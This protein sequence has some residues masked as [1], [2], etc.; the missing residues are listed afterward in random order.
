[1]AGKKLVLF[2]YKQQKVAGS[3]IYLLQ[4]AQELAKKN[5]YEEVYYVNLANKNLEEMYSCEKVHYCDA[6]TCDYSVFDGADFFIP[7]NYL[8]VFLDKAKGVTK[9]KVLLYNWHPFLFQFLNNQFLPDRDLSGLY[10]MIAENDGIAFMDESCRVSSMNQTNCGFSRNYIPVFQSLDKQP[11][12]AKEIVNPNEINIGWMGRI[13]SDKV[14]AL[15]NLLD[16]LRKVKTNKQIVLHIIGDG[17]CT[18]RI[19]IGRYAPKIRMVFTSYLF[20]EERDTYIK[21]NIDILVTMGMSALDVANLGIPTLIAPLSLT[22]MDQNQYVLLTDVENY[23]LGWDISIFKDL[24]YRHYLLIDIIRMVYDDGKKN[25]LGEACYRFCHENFSLENSTCC[26]TTAMENTTLSIEKCLGNEVVKRQLLDYQ[27]YKALRPQNNYFTFISFTGRIRNAKN[28]GLLGYVKLVWSFVKTNCFRS[29]TQ[30]V[31]KKIKSIK[32][33]RI[34]LKRY[35]RIQESYPQKIENIRAIADQKGRVNAAFFVI[36]SSVFQTE[37]VFRRMVKDDFFNPVIVVTPDMQRSE[38]QREECYQQTYRELREKYG[39]RVIHGYDVETGEYYDPEDNYQLV[40]FNNPY[41]KMAY[42]K[43]HVTYFLDKNALSI[44]PYYGFAA[45]QYGRN[46]MHTDFYNFVWKLCLDSQMNLEDLQK[47]QPIKGINGLVTGYLKMDRLAECEVRPRER[48]KIIIC[49]HHTVLGWKSLDI[50]NFL[51]YKDFFLQLP[52]KYPDVDFVFRPHPL[53]FSNLREN[54]LWSDEEIDNYINAMNAYK[55]AV[56]D[57]SG[58]YFDLFMNSDAMIHDCS[59]FIGEYLFTEKPCCYMLKS[60]N[61]LNTVLI[62]MGR[63]CLKQYYQAFSESDIIDFID[64]VVIKGNDPLK[65]QREAFSRKV[66]K[67]NYPNGT[68]SLISYI[69]DVL[70]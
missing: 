13:D 56:Y 10:Q 36:F 42:R 5:V 63:E 4:I 65:N 60:K 40:F 22:K 47:H 37:P 35:K 25:E 7:V 6:D 30:K 38:R 27:R 12:S 43:H 70:Q 54:G 33:K 26:F 45:V 15:L 24:N 66:L 52:A 19:K 21:E 18:G 9:G 41:S 28:A 67:F 51:V 39:D 64:N 50:S 44:Y 69:K 59:S 31:K 3:L 34:H 53:L 62:P 49:P 2:Y 48:K 23:S 14:Y 61:Q 1:M 58:D 29:V 8:F 16:N 68:Q 46:L 11:F 17:E 20:G 57:N 32:A 55:N